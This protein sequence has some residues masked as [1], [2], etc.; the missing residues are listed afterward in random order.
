[1]VC[2]RLA[3]WNTFSVF[4]L[5]DTCYKVS[6]N[7]EEQHQEPILWHIIVIR[8]SSMYCLFT[9]QLKIIILMQIFRNYIWQ[10]DSSCLHFT[11]LDTCIALVCDFRNPRID[12]SG[13]HIVQ[14]KGSFW[15]IFFQC[16]V[17]MKWR[18]ACW[19]LHCSTK[20]SEYSC[21][22]VLWYSVFLFPGEFTISN[23]L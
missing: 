1:M 8:S 14:I 10:F 3:A 21:E 18:S 2:K 20:I 7:R 17:T 22:W 5:T 12:F 11:A 6:Q 4:E 19:R 16:H 23:R 15:L 9:Y 13:L